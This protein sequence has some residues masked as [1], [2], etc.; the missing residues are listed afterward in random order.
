MSPLAKAGVGADRIASVTGL[1][2]VKGQNNLG[3]C[4]HISAGGPCSCDLLEKGTSQEGPHW[5]LRV[6]AR[7]ALAN[8]LAFAG[9]EAKSFTF[10]ARWLGEKIEHPQ[11][12]KLAVLVQAARE[13]R[14][15]KNTPLLVGSHPESV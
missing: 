4:L 14:L 7:E 6:D 12:V 2:V 15:P 3:S 13:N 5:V 9:K 8:A 10:Q 11:R 1:A